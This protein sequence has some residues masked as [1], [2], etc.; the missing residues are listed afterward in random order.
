MARAFGATPP[1][2]RVDR[3]GRVWCVGGHWCSRGSDAQ[4]TPTT[5]VPITL[6]AESNGQLR[7]PWGMDRAGFSATGKINRLDYGLNW[8]AA[9]ETGGFVVAQDVKITLEIEIT[10]PGN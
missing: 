5:S 8:N 10:K 3:A 1:R 6:S 2:C 4:I 9:L 7:D